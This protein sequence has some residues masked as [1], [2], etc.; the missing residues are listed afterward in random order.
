M[1]RLHDDGNRSI[2]LP[3][4]AHEACESEKYLEALVERHRVVD[5]DAQPLALDEL[6]QILQVFDHDLGGVSSCHPHA[7]P[8]PRTPC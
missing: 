4:V 2:N 8:A 7:L 5:Q 3:D 1:T 6:Q